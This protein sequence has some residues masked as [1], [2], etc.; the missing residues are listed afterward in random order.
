MYSYVSVI[1]SYAHIS[2][3][4]DR[5]I[6]QISMTNVSVCVCERERDRERERERERERDEI[7]FIAC[8]MI[9]SCNLEC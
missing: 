6:L 1:D 8:S 7:N 9:V 5:E 4:I 3:L 2:L